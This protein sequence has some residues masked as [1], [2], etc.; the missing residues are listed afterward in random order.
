MQYGAALAYYTVVS[1]GPLVV[2][3]VPL[4]AQILGSGAAESRIIGQ[5]GLLAGPQGAEIARTVLSEANRPDIGAVGTW[6]SIALFASAATAVFANLQGALNK[7]WGV[8]PVTGVVRNLL[9]TRLMAF[10]M[11]LGLGFLTILSFLMG[12]FLSWAGPLIE[13]LRDILPVVKLADIVTSWLLLWWFV[14]MVFSILPD[15]KISWKDVWVGAL[16]TSG[17]LVASRYALTAVV[18]QN[19]TASMY[20]AAGSIFL[21]L[22]W[23]Y[24]SA[25][26]FFLGAEFTEV[27]V[28]ERGREIRP[29]HYARRVGCDDEEERGRAVDPEPTGTGAAA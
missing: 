29:E 23:I 6:L 15:V 22:L 25:Q 2:L 21:L 10:A 13:P 24:I 19:A 1:I 12:A 20:G 18:A 9:R 17:L 11:V 16:A 26:I 28:E 14:G 3:S 4:L 8:E 7:I 5:A 27:W